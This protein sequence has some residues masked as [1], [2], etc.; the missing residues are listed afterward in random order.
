[1]CIHIS[2]AFNIFIFVLFYFRFIPGDA[3]CLPLALHSVITFGGLG[4][5]TS[6]QHFY[7]AH[8]IPTYVRKAH[9]QFY[10][11]PEFMDHIDSKLPV[12]TF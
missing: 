9:D 1:M 5:T 7:D 3:Y 4:G 12:S 11:G 6:Y 8:P 2:S 10:K